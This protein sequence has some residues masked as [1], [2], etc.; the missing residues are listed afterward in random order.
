MENIG[1]PTAKED[2]EK[3]VAE[4]FVQHPPADEAEH[5][6][7]GSLTQNTLDDLDFVVDTSDGKKF[8]ELMEFAPLSK[9][10]GKFENIPS[11]HN[12]GE[13]CDLYCQEVGR[14][15][16]KYQTIA[17]VY[18]LTY[19]TDRTLNL[20]A[21]RRLIMS[22]L[23]RIQLSLERVYYI[24]LHGSSGASSFRWYPVDDSVM[25]KEEEERWAAMNVRLPRQEEMRI[26]EDGVEV[27]WQPT[28]STNND[29]G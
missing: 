7:A 29:E 6:V 11:G 4:Q 12:L 23:N 20:M 8:L 16:A 14:K 3:Y 1:F 15:S 18:L 21:H 5:F 2:I 9:F 10:G 28:Q 24:S 27:P 22:I 17:N 25:S 26:T 19:V 13:F